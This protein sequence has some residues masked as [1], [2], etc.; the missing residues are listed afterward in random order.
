MVVLVVGIVIG[1]VAAVEGSHIDGILEP[2]GMGT[3]SPRMDLVEQYRRF[4]LDGTAG[5][6]VVVGLGMSDDGCILHDSV[7]LGGL[8]SMDHRH[9]EARFEIDLV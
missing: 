9:S 7:F 1:I 5:W 2:G 3:G 6:V 4:Q 8:L